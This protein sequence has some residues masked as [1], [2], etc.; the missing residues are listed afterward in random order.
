[1]KRTMPIAMTI[2]FCISLCYYLAWIVYGIY[3]SVNGVDEGWLI[4]SLSSGEIVYGVKAFEEAIGMCIVYT[5]MRYWFIPLY[6]A[7]YLITFIV[8]KILK[9]KKQKQ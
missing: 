8:E 1:M 9:K 4:P 5:V 7:I 3:L 6:Q 2:I